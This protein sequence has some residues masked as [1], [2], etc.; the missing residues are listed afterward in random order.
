VVDER[1]EQALAEHLGGL[2]AEQQLRGLAPLGDG[3]LA[4]G[5]DEEPVDELR[6]EIVER[7]ERTRRLVDV[8]ALGWCL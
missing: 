1:V 7:V 6:E 4:V 8:R 5:Q 2:E 3:A